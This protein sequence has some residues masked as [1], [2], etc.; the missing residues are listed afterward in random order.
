MFTQGF[1][2]LN[3]IS[4][5]IL[6]SISIVSEF[7]LVFRIIFTELNQEKEVDSL[8]SSVFFCSNT[9]N[10]FSYFIIKC[11]LELGFS[12]SSNFI[13]ILI[14]IN[15][16][17]NFIEISGFFIIVFKMYKKYGSKLKFYFYTYFCV[18]FAILYFASMINPNGYFN[19]FFNP[20]S[21]VA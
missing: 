1:L 3:L 19:I 2:F 5:G 9:S 20:M 13:S 17:S 15:N 8:I 6:Y 18:W 21:L 11:W 7:F 4:G 16:I 12:K 10:F 14:I